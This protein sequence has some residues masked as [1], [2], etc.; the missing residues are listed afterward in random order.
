MTPQPL[1]GTPTLIGRVMDAMDAAHEEWK[2]RG[3]ATTTLKTHIWRLGF[4]IARECGAALYPYAGSLGQERD[5][6]AQVSLQERGAYF[7]GRDK[8]DSAEEHS[9]I[10]EFQYDVAWAEFDDEY[11]CY[12]DDRDTAWQVPNFKRLVLALETELN[13]PYRWNV[14]Y[15]FHKLLA[16][17]AELRVMVWNHR[18]RA[19]PDGFDMLVPRLC[20]NGANE[21]WWLLSPWSDDGFREHRVYHNGKR[22]K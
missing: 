10:R 4:E 13:P 8:R 21:G 12:A 15:D 14:L 17:R 11:P 2:S 20:A 16:A 6:Y 7:W 5:C 9:T 1:P 19:F 22:Q 18:P 3:S